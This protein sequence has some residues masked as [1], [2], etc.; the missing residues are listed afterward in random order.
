[1]SFEKTEVGPATLYQGDCLEILAA[2]LLPPNAAIVSDPPY[3]IG[4]EKGPSG[5]GPAVLKDHE[6]TGAASR[7]VGDDRPFD[8]TPWLDYAAA[9]QARRGN[10][11]MP[12][13]MS[14]ALCGADHFAHRLP[15]RVGCFCAWDKSCGGGPADSFTDLELIWIGNRNPRRL[16]REIWKGRMR[17]GIAT[18]RQHVSEKPVGLM[19]WLLET[20]RIPLSR[21]VLDPYMGSGTTGV[22]CL[23]T[24]RRFIGV[25]IDPGHYATACR[26]IAET[27]AEIENGRRQHA[28]PLDDAA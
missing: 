2:G 27:W 16:Y 18:A 8:P 6:R 14:V 25:E 7:I 3:G 1:M 21:P 4:F 15:P 20:A 17:N 22:A 19:R 13:T 10:A 12:G 28:L 11:K 5:S 9:G 24:G 23:Q 26:R